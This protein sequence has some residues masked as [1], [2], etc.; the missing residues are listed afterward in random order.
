MGRKHPQAR[1]RPRK[2]PH[3]AEAVS[4]PA[5]VAA[6]P[7]AE[8]PGSLFSVR[9]TIG[10]SIVAIIGV[11]VLT[12]AYWKGTTDTRETL[13]FAVL[14]GALAG[15]LLSAYYVWYG[16]GTALKQRAEAQEQER[17]KTALNF[18][19]RWNDPRM[20]ESRHK[21]RTILDEF[22]KDPAATQRSLQQDLTKRTVVAD[23]LNFFEEMAY[24]AISG[25][26][27]MDTLQEM[28]D[29]VCLDY[30]STLRPWIEIRRKETGSKGAWGQ[31]ERLCDLWKS[32]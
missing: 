16:L 24:S 32:V 12:G 25:A 26:A 10:C 8:K 20:A 29:H 28:F 3:P 21:W 31:M 9:A 11:L 30:F 15:G 14:A 1:P 2:S 18:V 27:D 5:P 22:R 19:T 4:D 7:P 23:I 13:E 17:I 6:E